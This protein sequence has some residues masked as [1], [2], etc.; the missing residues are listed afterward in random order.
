MAP[1][2]NPNLI[3]VFKASD[4]NQK[5]LADPKQLLAKG[6]K[7]VRWTDREAFLKGG[8]AST[9]AKGGKGGKGKPAGGEDAPGETSEP[10]APAADAAEVRAAL[11]A[12][13]VT[14]GVTIHHKMSNDT[15]RKKIDEAKAKA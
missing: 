12:E 2:P 7:L 3:E 11:E 10:E 1:T 4:P 6:G 15:I 8:K 14:A 13:A 9:P 5:L